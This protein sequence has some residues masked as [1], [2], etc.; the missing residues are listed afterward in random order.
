MSHLRILML[1]SFYPPDIGGAQRQI[2]LLSRELVRRGHSVAVVTIW[3]EGLPEREDDQGVAVYRMKGLTTRVPWFSQEAHRRHHPPFPD[4]AI[5]HGLRRLIDQF[6]PDVVHSYAWITYSGAAALFGRS[7]PLVISA[8]TYAYTCPITSMLH[9]G[10]VCDGP[11]P[12]KCLECAAH[13]YGSVAKSVVAV[14]GVLGGKAYLKRKVK[15]VHSVSTFVQETIRSDLFDGEPV[16]DAVIPSFREKVAPKAPDPEFLSKLPE[17]PFILF[18]GALTPHKGLPILLEAYRQLAGAPRLI[19][20]GTVRG[21]TPEHFPPDVA[22]FND[23]P[24]QDVMAAWE[25]CLFGVSPSLWPEPFA[26]VVH[27][28]MSKGKAMIGTSAGGYTDIIVDGENGLLVPPGDMMALA[29]A[30]RRLIDD[31]ALRERLGRAAKE[32][33]SMYTAEL[34]VPRF[35]ALYHQVAGLSLGSEGEVL[36]PSPHI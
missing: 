5:V 35:E 33:A 8:R 10:E 6:Q 17:Q 12:L 23:V 21:D 19:L 7:I 29:Q 11:A 31:P 25:R 24:H 4:P 1:S 3:Q 14:A 26:N 16:L 27:E 30:L 36:G 34:M 22:V 2:Q 13:R 9:H 20:I 15:G 28:C 18:V 32:R